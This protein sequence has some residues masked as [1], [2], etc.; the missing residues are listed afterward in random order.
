MQVLAITS[1]E[2][3][4]QS[5]TCRL[6]AGWYSDQFYL[7][8][9]E[10]VFGVEALCKTKGYLPIFIMTRYGVHTYVLF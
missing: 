4:E 2:Q 3:A 10:L 6:A 9:Q 5:L 7:H 8:T 1:V